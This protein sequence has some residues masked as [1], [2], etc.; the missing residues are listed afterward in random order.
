MLKPLTV[1]DLPDFF[2]VMK[3]FS[4]AKEG[5]SPEDMLKNMTDEGLQAL[6]RLIEKTLKISF[7]DEPEEDR[8][9]FGLKYMTV[10]ITK[11]MELNSSTVQTDDRKRKVDALERLHKQKNIDLKKT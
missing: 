5:A 2:K 11:I 1:D 3:A 8:K 7:P 4:G 9:A 10:L 6:K